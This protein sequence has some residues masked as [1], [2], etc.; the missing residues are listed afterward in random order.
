VIKPDSMSDDLGGE[1]MA[2]MRVGRRFH[3]ANRVYLRPDCPERVTVT[4]PRRFLRHA[5]IAIGIMKTA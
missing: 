5:R 4:M 3:A 2:V 1:A